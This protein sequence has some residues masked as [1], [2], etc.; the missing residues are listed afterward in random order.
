MSKTTGTEL[1]LIPPTVA[2][3]V[4]ATVDPDADPLMTRLGAMTT[5]E[6]T[7]YIKDEIALG[8]RVLADEKLAADEHKRIKGQRLQVTFEVICALRELKSRCKA[9]KTW[10]KAL[11]EC[12]IAPSTWRSWDCRELNQLTTGKRT[13]S[14]KAKPDGRSLAQI[15]ADLVAAKAAV[16]AERAASLAQPDPVEVEAEYIDEP[17]GVVPAEEEDAEPEVVVKWREAARESHEL[18]N[19]SADGKTERSMQIAYQFDVPYGERSFRSFRVYQQ[20]GKVGRYWQTVDGWLGSIPKAG[21]RFFRTKAEALAAVMEAF[22]VLTDLTLA[23]K[24][25]PTPGPPAPVNKPEPPEP[26]KVVNMGTYTNHGAHLATKRAMAKVHRDRKPVRLCPKCHE[27]Y[28][29]K[30]YMSSAHQTR[31]EHGDGVGADGAFIPA[32]LT[33]HTVF[34]IPDDYA[35]TR[36]AENAA[37]IEAW[38]DRTTK[39]H[40]SA[41][42]KTRKPRGKCPRMVDGV[43]CLKPTVAPTYLCPDHIAEMDAACDKAAAEQ[44]AAV[45]RVIAAGVRSEY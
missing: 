32:A 25:G 40:E 7:T 21:M 4:S 2:V 37:K 1:A 30:Y 31:Y 29:R 33:S 20:T 3:E 27:P 24:T 44:D 45:D 43:M 28:T 38:N 17:T 39:G 5:S 13:K 22:N 6:L 26:T 12:G 35:P 11:K 8:E 10:E 15:Q 34:G 16:D 14:R 36:D 23:T 42:A 41:Q 9:S 18:I 19:W